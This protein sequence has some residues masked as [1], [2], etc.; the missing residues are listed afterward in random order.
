VVLVEFS[1]LS[2]L[3]GGGFDLFSF[4]VF[5]FCFYLHSVFPFL[6]FSR[7]EMAVE[8]RIDGPD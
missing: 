6:F 1:F 4:F 8:R 3:V 2:L 7:S 5:L